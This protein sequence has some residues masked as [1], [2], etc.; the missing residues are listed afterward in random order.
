M[1]RQIAGMVNT[2]PHPAW[3]MTGELADLV[4]GFPGLLCVDDE[5]PFFLLFHHST[6]NMCQAIGPIDILP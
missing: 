2:C 3:F 1:L 5:R 4:V 6:M